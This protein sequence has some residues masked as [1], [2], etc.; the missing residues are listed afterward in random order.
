MSG[1]SFFHHFSELRLDIVGIVAILGEG[2]T[3]RNAPASALRWHHIL[4]R[5]YPAPQALLKHHQ[6]KGLATEPGIVIGALSGRIRH[7]LNFFTQL[8]HEDNLPSYGVQLL[9]IYKIKPKEK[10][11]TDTEAQAPNKNT[12]PA[13]EAKKFGYLA[14]LSVLGC[15]MSILLLVLAVLHNDGPALLANICLSMTSSLVG[16]ASWCTL[17]KNEEVPDQDRK[18]NVPLGDVV[19]FYPRQGAFRVVRC[20]DQ[21]A[22]LYFRHERFIHV[23]GDNVYRTLALFS[24]VLLM[25]GL[26]MLGNSG[27]IMQAAFAASYILLNAL[28][29]WSSAWSPRTHVWEHHYKIEKLGFTRRYITTDDETIEPQETELYPAPEEHEEH[30]KAVIDKNSIQFHTPGTWKGRKFSRVYTSDATFARG[31]HL[32]LQDQ[33]AGPPLFDFQRLRSISSRSERSIGED[34]KTSS[35][36][37]E[38]NQYKRSLTSALWTVIA[39]TGTSRWARTS[40][41][42]PDTHVWNLWLQEA[43]NKARARWSETA[44]TYVPAC[45]AYKEKSGTLWIKLPEWEYGKRLTELLKEHGGAETQRWEVPIDVDDFQKRFAEMKRRE[46]A[47]KAIKKMTKNWREEKS[48]KKDVASKKLSKIPENAITTASAEQSTLR[49]RRES[50][51]SGIL[52]SRSSD[53]APRNEVRHVNPATPTGEASFEQEK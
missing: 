42:A 28:Y 39:L 5:I 43:E 44:G 41:I 6:Q 21:D 18:D 14:F 12:T 3:S 13:F 46:G 22:R 2:S 38:K 16:I 51:R 37:A 9:K 34:P 8:L 30:H 19:I 25:C 24:T 47:V 26:I 35:P 48:R 33:D 11:A 10:T 52:W 17:D 27:P 53:F 40:Q 1:V 29:W 4:P 7:E 20:S 23:C 15:C 45:I 36:D 49:L 32:H 31:H 50:L